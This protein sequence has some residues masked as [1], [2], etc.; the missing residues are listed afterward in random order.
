[1]NAAREK[2]RVAR[3]LEELPKIA[4]RFSSGELSYSKV[5]AMTRVA[6]PQNQDYLLM[7]ARHGTAWHLEQLV[8]Q[9]RRVKRLQESAEAVHL[10]EDSYLRH[11]YDEDGSLVIE[12]RLPPDSGA[13]VI[14]ALE[15]ASEQ[16]D[17][18]G[19]AGDVSA[20][21]LCADGETGRCAIEG[22]PGIAA[23]TARMARGRRRRFR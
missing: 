22:G 9:Y 20:E 6:T 2:V 17:T 16:M 13:L 18:P 11:H 23:D 19:T 1:M 14:K 15:A 7:I 4:E 8:R 10:N 21:T 5:R 12:A 3:A